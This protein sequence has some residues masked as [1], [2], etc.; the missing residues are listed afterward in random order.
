MKYFT[1]AKFMSG[2]GNK[3]GYTACG[4]GQY[5]AGAVMWLGRG[6]NAQKLLFQS[7]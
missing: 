4:Q 5:R 3:A 7:T 2:T 1:E 6:G